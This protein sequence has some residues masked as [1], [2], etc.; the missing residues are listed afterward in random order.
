MQL[1]IFDYALKQGLTVDVLV[2]T[3]RSAQPAV[4]RRVRNAAS[5]GVPGRPRAEENDGPAPCHR[6]A[7]HQAT[8]WAVRASWVC[9]TNRIPISACSRLRLIPGPHHLP[10]GQG[11]L[12]SRCRYG[13]PRRP[14]PD[15]SR[16]PHRVAQHRPLRR[17]RNRPQ[18]TVGSE[19]L[20]AQSYK[21]RAGASG[22]RMKRPSIPFSSAPTP[23]PDTGTAFVVATR[24]SDTCPGW[25]LAP[26]SSQTAPAAARKPLRG[27]WPSPPGNRKACLA[28]ACTV[29]HACQMTA[30]Y[31]ISELQGGTNLGRKWRERERGNIAPGGGLGALAD[32]LANDPALRF[33]AV[34]L[35]LQ[36]G[37][38]SWRGGGHG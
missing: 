21:D 15:P 29:G 27:P 13:L 23:S 7:G 20:R 31:R 25:Q 34:C 6:D 14:R 26:S 19:I 17:N 10:A 36:K 24:T 5:D 8:L 12:A 28:L 30:P 33:R 32:A 2:D 18:Q 38:G 37:A 3:K 11:D 1:A 16:Q 35:G 9:G 4:Q 22:S